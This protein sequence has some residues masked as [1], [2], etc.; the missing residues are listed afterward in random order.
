MDLALAEPDFVSATLRT[1]PDSRTLKQLTI[2]M[3]DHWVKVG[4]G[5]E[6]SGPPRPVA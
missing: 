2:K 3:R 4:P 6:T 5:L 1:I